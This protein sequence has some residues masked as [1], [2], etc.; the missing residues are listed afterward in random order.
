MKRMKRYGPTTVMVVI[1]IFVAVTVAM[2]LFIW[3]PN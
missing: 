3:R 1:Y 2:D